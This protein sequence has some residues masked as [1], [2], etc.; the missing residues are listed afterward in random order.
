M[1]DEEIVV[2]IEG[3]SALSASEVVAVDDTG[4]TTSTKKA[5][6]DD[7]VESLKSQLAAKQTELAQVQ[8][9]ATSAETVASQMQARTQRA[10]R[11]A[12]VARQDAHAHTKATIDSGIAA[13][14]SEADAAQQAYETAFE[15]GNAKETA[16]AQRRLADAAADLR[17]LQQAKA[18]LAEAPAPRQSEPKPA[19]DPVEEFIGRHTAPTQAWMRA[20]KDYLTDP[21][22]NARMQA[23]HFDAVANDH[24]P[25]TEAYFDHVERKLGLKTDQSAAQ[26]PPKVER[27]PTAPVAPSGSAPGA[28]NGGKVSVT[29][30]RGELAAAEDGTH[31]WNYDDPSPAKKFKKGDPIG[32]TEFAR[33][34]AAM[35]KEGRYH[36]INVDGT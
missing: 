6:D 10:E 8:Q 23:A 33:R 4:K 34:K 22:K 27:R 3:D 9:R 25:D 16:K 1:A 31:T 24:Q 29:L 17:Y 28:M 2:E 35:M 13:A 21:K 26:D 20:H 19:A 7:I 32:R 14:K 15:S 30:T 18:D 11:E 5:A 36:N 12:Q